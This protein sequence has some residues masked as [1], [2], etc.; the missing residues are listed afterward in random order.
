MDWKDKRRLLATNILLFAVLFLLVKF[1][2]EYLRPQFGT[3]PFAGILTGSL[4]NFLAALL[5]SLC[6]V[7][8]VLARMPNRRRTIVYAGSCLVFLV[9]AI[10]ELRPMWGAST[11][12][13]PYDIVASALGSLMAI[14]IFELVVRTGETKGKGSG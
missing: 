3:L 7:N 2:K 4:P 13:D 5:I 14:L 8:A 10:E 11:R 6:A 9:L 12:Y 1:N